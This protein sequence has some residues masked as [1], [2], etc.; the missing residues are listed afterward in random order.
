MGGIKSVVDAE[1]L[2]EHYCSQNDFSNEELALGIPVREVSSMGFELAI[3]VLE[4]EP[5]AIKQAEEC[6][7][8]K[9]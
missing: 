5:S 9:R 4:G 1:I 8:S 3:A 7:R 6:L 2:Y